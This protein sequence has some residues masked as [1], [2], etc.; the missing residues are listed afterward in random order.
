LCGVHFGFDAKL[1][2]FAWS[3]S[4]LGPILILL[5]AFPEISSETGDG[6]KSFCWL[7]LNRSNDLWVNTVLAF[8]NA[9]VPV[10]CFLTAAVSYAVVYF[11]LRAEIRGASKRTS[12]YFCNRIATVA[13]R[14][15]LA[16]VITWGPYIAVRWVL[17]VGCWMLGVGCWVIRCRSY[18]S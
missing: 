18:Y 12:E 2:V 1:S 4:F 15:L 10:V 6:W 17:G 11:K 7:D 9:L 8:F 14:Y 13:S 5:F 16:Y 3:S